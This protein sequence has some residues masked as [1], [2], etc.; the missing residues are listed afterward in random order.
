MDALTCQWGLEKERSRWWMIDG[1]ASG[2]ALFTLFSRRQSWKQDAASLTNGHVARPG[3]H[4]EAMAQTCQLADALSQDANPKMQVLYICT[5][6]L[7]SL[8]PPSHEWKRGQSRQQHGRS[9]QP[10]TLC[11]AGP[12]DRIRTTSQH[13]PPV[14]KPVAGRLL[15]HSFIACASVPVSPRSVFQHLTRGVYPYY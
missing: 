15:R 4:M 10:V 12:F 2:A 14:R 5:K 13:A 9:C 7:P 6:P 11:V 1:K 3:E 8:S